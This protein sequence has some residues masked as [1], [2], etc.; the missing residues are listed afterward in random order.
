MWRNRHLKSLY[1]AA[2][3]TKW[4]RRTDR[5]LP[6]CIIM[7]ASCCSS[8]QRSVH[9]YSYLETIRSETIL[10]KLMYIFVL[11]ILVS[12]WLQCVGKGYNSKATGTKLNFM[13]SKCVALDESD[14]Y[15]TRYLSTLC[16]V[17]L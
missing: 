1:T 4:R 13:Q 12:T 11:L 9:N 8:G 17:C 16:A 6:I 5:A 3:S 15:H 2:L 7:H 10:G 14:G